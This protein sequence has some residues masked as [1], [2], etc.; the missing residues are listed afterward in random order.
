MNSRVISAR[1]PRQDKAEEGGDAVHR[2]LTTTQ[3][4]G[5]QPGLIAQGF[6][7]RRTGIRIKRRTGFPESR[8]SE[9]QGFRKA[10]AYMDRLLKEEDEEK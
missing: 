1:Y 5:G 9:K 4:R 3:Y 8:D 10:A 6:M 2:P 7:R